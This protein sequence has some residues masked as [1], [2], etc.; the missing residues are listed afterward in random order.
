MP[1][2]CPTFAGVVALQKPVVVSSAGQEILVSAPFPA[3]V[4]IGSGVI[5]D[6]LTTPRFASAGS[7]LEA[8]PQAAVSETIAIAI[9]RMDDPGAREKSVESELALYNLI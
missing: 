1:S 3:T 6:C 2:A 8:K 4:G 5:T 9:R 7:R